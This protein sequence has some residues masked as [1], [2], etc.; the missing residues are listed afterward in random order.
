[1]GVVTYRVPLKPG[2][3]QALV[4]KIPIAP[5]PAGTD[6][7]KQVQ[8][9]EYSQNLERTVSF[10]EDLVS[11]ACPLR[12]PEA[13]VQEALLANTI[14]DL[15]A[16][17]K[18]G[19]DYIPNVNKFQYHYFYGGSDTSHMLVALDYL[20]LPEIAGKAALYSIKAQSAEGAYVGRD[21]T[22][23]THYWE[24]FG[25]TLWTW[26]R[27]YRL[28]RDAAFLHQVYP[29]V[30]RAMDW[31]KRIT[32]KEPLGLMPTF[33]VPDDAFLKDAHQTG[34]DLW[35]L[36]GIRN[37]IAM[38]EGMGRSQ[39][40][41]RFEAEY[42]RF[43]KAFEKQLD[44]QTAKTGGHIP[45]GLDRTLSGNNWDNLL[46]L[47]PE[48][49]FSPFD[50]RVAATN[51]ESRKTY[52][53]GILGYVLPRATAGKDGEYI[54][55][56]TRRLHYWHSLDNAENGLVRGAPED[57][58][59]AVKDLY[60][61]LLHTTSTHA[62]QE[63]GTQP[64]S[65]RDYVSGDILPDGAASGVLVELM[66]NMLVR[67][68]NNDLF[69]FSAI[70]PAWLQPGKRIEV[71]NE[72]TVFGPVTAIFEVALEGWAVK[73]S[74][75]FRQAPAHVVLCVPW[76]YD[77]RQAEADISPA[78]VRD[79]KLI[80]SP[81]TREVKVTGRIKP[82]TP[83]MSFEHTVEDYGREYRRRYQEFLRTGTTQ[84]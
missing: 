74:N 2:E 6:E 55:D 47:Y 4:F 83:A 45:P 15:L 10:W 30:L 26:G 59:S 24:M 62:P 77:V 38:S 21:D 49:L 36:A 53:E 43:W 20:G 67:E 8:E 35:T 18:V 9:A 13:K 22:A 23:V 27:H 32:E 73:L 40:V 51:R 81:R 52:S 84:P 28:T 54:F 3:S 70:S 12:F 5:I 44:T 25:N 48:P 33:G 60:A 76:F 79:G 50:A 80:L 56:S 42:E 1:M 19:V 69:L 65:T 63:F 66:R 17:D 41:A 75:Q 7:A 72:P 58:E 34:Q 82:G 78:E 37:A 16:I 11:K 71:V 46:M 29:S 61:M 68:Y 39:D 31:E 64:W 57:Q 14:F